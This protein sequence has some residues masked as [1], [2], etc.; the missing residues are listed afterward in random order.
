MASIHS[1]CHEDWSRMREAPGGRFCDRCDFTVI[2]V[3]A[4]PPGQAS[5]FLNRDLPEAT[6]A[7]RRVCV[8]AVA[9]RRGFLLR[10]GWRRLTNGVAAILAMSLVGCGTDDA[11]PVAQQESQPA[12][13]T[14]S[15]PESGPSEVNQEKQST[16]RHPG[17]D[18]GI[19]IDLLISESEQPASPTQPVKIHDGLAEP[20]IVFPVERFDFG[21]TT[22]FVALGGIGVSPKQPKPP[23]PTQAP[24]PTEPEPNVA[25]PLPQGKT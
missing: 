18:N 19:D 1:P 3:T 13:P 11:P 9:D 14:K 2:D 20:D 23:A 5:Q 17:R 24:V 25:P 22:G 8:R 4:M 10:P 6:G 21:H 15:A 12:A 16:D 7:G